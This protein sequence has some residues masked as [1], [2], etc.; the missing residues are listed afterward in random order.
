MMQ[1]QMFRPKMQTHKLYNE[2]Q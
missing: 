2:V 1:T